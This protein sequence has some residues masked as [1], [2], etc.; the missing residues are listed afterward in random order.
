MR[1]RGPDGPFRYLDCDEFVPASS[2]DARLLH[3]IME[4]SPLVL[5]AITPIAR[6]VIG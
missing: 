2:S 6:D 4:A 1:S 5:V 3:T